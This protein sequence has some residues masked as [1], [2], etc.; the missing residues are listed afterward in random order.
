VSGPC[1]CRG[2]GVRKDGERECREIE[3]LADKREQNFVTTLQAITCHRGP[4]TLQAITCLP[5]PI[6][7]T[8]ARSRFLPLPQHPVRSYTTHTH[9]RTHTHT[10]TNTHTHTHTHSFVKSWYDMSLVLVV[11]DSSLNFQPVRYQV[12]FDYLPVRHAGKPSL[13]KQASLSLSLSVCHVRKQCA[14]FH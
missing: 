7:P 14:S 5:F 6:T 1:V 8:L 13:Q 4:T 10:H 12:L 9:T 2:K 11:P 3:A